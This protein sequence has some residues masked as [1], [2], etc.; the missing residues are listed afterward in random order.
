MPGLEGGVVAGAIGVSGFVSQTTT[1]S[2]PLDL[3]MRSTCRGSNI[4]LHNK[5][6]LVIG[7]SSGIGKGVAHFAAAELELIGRDVES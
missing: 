3:S 7:G 5:F 4:L 2:S 1:L 6:V